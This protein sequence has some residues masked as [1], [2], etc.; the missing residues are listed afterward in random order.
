MGWLPVLTGGR[1][2]KLVGEFGAECPATGFGCEH[3]AWLCKD[4]RSAEKAQYDTF[5]C[6]A[7][8][9]RRAAF[10]LYGVL[11]K[12]GLAVELD[13]SN[14]TADEAAYAAEKIGGVIRILDEDNVEIHYIQSGETT[15]VKISELVKR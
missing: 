10:E 7:E 2:D 5:V 6:Y 11:R 4:R 8:S 3:G 13:I 9:S 1:Y 15:S 14:R 12:Q